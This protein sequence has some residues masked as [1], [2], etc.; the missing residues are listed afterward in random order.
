MLRLTQLFEARLQEEQSG[1]HWVADGSFFSYSSLL[2]KARRQAQ[3]L[4]Q[5]GLTGKRIL[6]VGDNSP[7]LVLAFLACWWA[8]AVPAAV[9]PPARLQAEGGYAWLLQGAAETSEASCGFCDPKILNRC[10]E[11]SLASGWHPLPIPESTGDTT[12]CQHSDNE[13][14]YLQFSSGTTLTPKATPLSHRNI[15][16]NLEAI[17]SQHPGGRQGHSCVSWLPLYHDMGLIGGLLSSIYCPGSLSLMTPTAFALNPGRWLDQIAYSRATFSV[18]PNF[19]LEQLLQRDKCDTDRDLS[20]LQ[21]LLLGAETIYPNT[22]EAFYERYRPQGLKWEA[23]TPVYGLAEATLGVTFSQGPHFGHFSLPTELG[24]AVER[25]EGRTLLSLG[26]PL[27]GVELSI[28]DEQGCPLPQ[29]HFGRICIAGPGLAM[30]LEPPYFTGDLGFLW[31]DELY[32]VTRQ[33]DILIY[34]GRNHDPEVAEQLLQ[35]LCSAAVSTENEEI[36]CLVEL[37]RKSNE[38]PESLKARLSLHLS[39]APFPTRPV[40][41]QHGWLPRTSSGK[42]SR[43]RARLKYH[44]ELQRGL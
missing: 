9:A 18:A 10:S 1:L 32:F 8:G 30:G 38:D 24:K 4:T 25:G 6:L 27:P 3:T 15:L 44:E 16:S 28:R 23:L 43:Y 5:M 26:H 22:L 12:L 36:L 34:H 42:I 37:P 20:C 33:K 41:V 29:G 13:L 14:A 17:A 21:R 40:L 39:K 11:A 7:Q 31:D 35:P 2:H 19:A